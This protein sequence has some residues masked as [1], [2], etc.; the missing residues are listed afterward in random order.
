MV[1]S[2]IK[3]TCMLVKY[4][5]HGFTLLVNCKSW[6]HYHKGHENRSTTGATTIA[7]VVDYG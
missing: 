2:Y 1:T 6:G 3:E 4:L 5:P 7:L